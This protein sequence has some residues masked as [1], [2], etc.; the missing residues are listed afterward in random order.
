[1]RDIAV[2]GGGMRWRISA[3]KSIPMALNYVAGAGRVVSDRCRCC[4]RRFLASK[5]AMWALIRRW[6]RPTS[7]AG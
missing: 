7:R 6:M 4:R 5:A 1:M 2:Y 3:G